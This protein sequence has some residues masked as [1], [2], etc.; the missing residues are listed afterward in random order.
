MEK[1]ELTGFR[2]RVHEARRGVWRKTL[3]YMSAGL[4]LVIGLAWND[5]IVTFINRVFPDPRNTVIAK[6]VYAFVITFL[7]GLVLFYVERAMEDKKDG[8]K[9]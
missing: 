6:F 8:E 3:T 7:V 5:A 9:K 2:K 4:G 1:E